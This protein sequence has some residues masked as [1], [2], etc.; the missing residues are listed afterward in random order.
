[1]I[2]HIKIH[3]GS[4]YFDFQLEYGIQKYRLLFKHIQFCVM[5]HE[6]IVV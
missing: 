3:S 2:F 1:M 4:Y 6:K 5:Q